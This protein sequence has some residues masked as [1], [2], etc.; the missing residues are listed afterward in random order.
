MDTKN[1]YIVKILI[2]TEFTLT[3][4]CG[5]VETK[6]CTKDGQQNFIDLDSGK[7]YTYRDDIGYIKV[8][9]DVALSEYYYKIGLRKKNNYRDKDLVHELVQKA[10]SKGKL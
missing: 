8:I 6:L 1:N 2:P 7:T 5:Y 3:T 4:E 10:K 9:N